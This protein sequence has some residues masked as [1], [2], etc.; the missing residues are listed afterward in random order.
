MIKYM[1]DLVLRG[2]MISQLKVAEKTQT[3]YFDRLEEV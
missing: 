1:P 3:E 2:K